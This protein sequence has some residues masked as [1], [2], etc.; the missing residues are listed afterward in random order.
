MIGCLRGE[1]E[2]EESWSLV[3]W[4]TH[5]QCLGG[6]PR[7]GWIYNMRPSIFLVGALTYGVFELIA[8]I[9]INWAF[10]SRYCMG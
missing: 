9:Y 7:R 6:G 10:H 2:G 8:R 3:C 5:T 4:Y 1:R